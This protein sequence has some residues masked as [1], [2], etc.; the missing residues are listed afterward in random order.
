M[1]S[2]LESSALGKTTAYPSQYDPSV[3]FAVARA[4]QRAALGIGAALPFAGADLWTAYELSWLDARGKPQVAIAA[5]RV[6]AE[7]A[8]IVESKSVKL[9]INSFSESRF[10]APEDVARVLRE[11]LCRACDGPVAVEL[12]EPR[13]F[14]SAT[15]QELA[16]ESIDDLDVTGERAAPAPELLRADGPPVEEALV[17]SLFKS[18]CPITGQPDWASVQVRYRGPRI[19]RAGLLGYI[20]SFRRHA[21]FHEHCVERMFVDIAQRCGPQRLTVYARFT[22]RGGIDINPFR[23]NWE[24]APA[25]SIRTPR[26]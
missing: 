25:V 11:D 18:N 12:H 4:E 5:F 16:G 10:A 8:N 9:Y 1:S 14:R 6:G 26:Q 21:G 17:S 24:A 19:D 15:L 2:S 7:S 20:I 3:L 22:R 13:A 23:S